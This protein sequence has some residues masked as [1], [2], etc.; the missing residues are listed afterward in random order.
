MIPIRLTIEGLYSY[1]ERQT[2]DFAHLVDAGLFGIFGAV[3]SGKSSILEAVTFALYGETERLNLREKRYYNMMNL[4]SNRAYIEFDFINFENRLFRATREFKRNSKNFEDVKS[5][6]VQFYE[7]RGGHWIPIEHTQASDIIGLSYDNFKRTIIIPQGQFKEFIELGPT[8]RTKMMK[9]IFHLQKY[10]LQDNASKLIASNKSELDQLEGKL[11]G[12]EEVS[13]E[14]IVDIQQKLSIEKE[15]QQKITENFNRINE[16]FQQIRTLK[17]EADILAQN[18]TAFKTLEQKKPDIEQ[19]KREFDKYERVFQL[20]N[21]SMAEKSIIE[22]GIAQKSFESEQQQ[23]EFDETNRTIKELEDKVNALKPEYDTLDQQKQQVADLA[24]IIKLKELEEKIKEAQNRTAKGRNAVEDYQN[25]ASE[26]DTVLKSKIQE[27]EELKKRRTDAELLMTVSSWYQTY[28][29]LSD[30][31]S[32]LQI[33]LSKNK[34]EIKA[35]DT[36]LQELGVTPS[37]LGTFFDERAKLLV[38]NIKEAEKTERQL[39][40]EDRLAQYAHTLHDGEPCPLCGALEHPH[41]ASGEDASAR[42]QEVKAQLTALNRQ[43]DEQ[44][45]LKAKA[46]NI[47]HTQIRYQNQINLLQSEADQINQQISLHKE[48]FIW[49]EFDMEN[50]ASFE[51]RAKEAKEV[52]NAIS[53]LEEI[54]HAKR[55]ELDN[56][57]KD[58]EKFD[59]ALQDIELIEARSTAEFDT[60]IGHLKTLV[61]DDFATTTK[62]EINMRH[63]QL[64]QSTE[65]L[66]RIYKETERALNTQNIRFAAL[67]AALDSTKKALNDYRSKLQDINDRIAHDMHQNGFQQFDEIVAILHKKIDAKQVRQE[68]EQFTVA[69]ETLKNKINEQRAKFEKTPFNQEIFEQKQTTL[70]NARQEWDSINSTVTKLTVEHSRLQQAYLSKKELLQR[71]GVLQKRAENLKTIFNMLKGNGFVQ[72]VSS[73]FLR[74]LCDNANTRFH[75]MTRNQLSLTLNENNDF[76]I[77]DYL[78][79]GKSRSVKTLSGGQAFQVSLSLALALAESVQ[80]NAKADKN[81]F[82]IDEGFGTQDNESINIVFETLLSL[83]RENRIVGIISHVEE[84]KERIPASITVTKDEEKG[85]II[86]TNEN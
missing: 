69:Y 40:V 57:R 34:D 17:E 60:T 65:R 82:F 29:S 54:I 81:F 6:V 83:Q 84:L 79:E 67:K 19:K 74:Q 8:D 27:L 28:R 61:Y 9:E 53:V 5:S 70:N 77:I 21:A 14:A 38:S 56:I 2:I 63:A 22:K 26:A 15:N 50:T 41:I 59:K 86:A 73:I 30:S 48:K 25:R 24:I 3:G 71:Q 35:L 11:S 68:F 18:L 49:P 43:K 39:L 78:N 52:N 46:E 36:Q 13:E 20:F 23:T 44:I 76:E 58:L 64:I 80:S 62:E 12:F 45:Q 31:L 37:N 4:K 55:Q 75:R 66:E 51:K 72:Y 85:S 47:V 42:I 33:D 10:D 16:E 32:K 7:S 1:Q